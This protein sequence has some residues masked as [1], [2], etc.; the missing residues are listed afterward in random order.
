MKR[1]ETNLNEKAIETAVVALHGEEGWRRILTAY[2][3]VNNA[4]VAAYATGSE[5]AAKMDADKVEQL[6]K[7]EFERG[8]KTGVEE[9][10]GGADK[11]VD[12]WAKRLY[13]EV[14]SAHEAEMQRVFGGVVSGQA[15]ALADEHEM[16]RDSG[17]ENDFY[18][19]F[20]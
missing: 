12:A 9:A 16:Q 1:F 11:D 6:R 4:M 13:P 18:R 5:E 3:L 8:Y 15:K 2:H 7:V 14:L 17:D 19:P 10:T 20:A